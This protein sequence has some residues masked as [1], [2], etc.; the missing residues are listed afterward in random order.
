M[1]LK[2]TKAIVIGSL[3]GVIVMLGSVVLPARLEVWKQE[4]AGQEEETAEAGAASLY[5]SSKLVESET[6]AAENGQQEG[7]AA[8]EKEGV[9]GPALELYVPK[10]QTEP[11]GLVAELDYV[12]ADKISFHG[13]FGYLVYELCVSEDGSVRAERKRAIS[14]EEIGGIHMGGG[15]YTEILANADMAL[16]LPGVR[17]PEIQRQVRYM[18]VEETNE[19][20]GGV[21]T[22]EW[23]SEKTAA[24]DYTD[25]AVKTEWA[26]E[27]SEL[28]RKQ[29]YGEI[30]YGPVEIPEYS[31]EVCGFLYQNGEK[32][33]DVRYGLWMRTENRIV[34]IP[35]FE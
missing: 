34:E 2:D 9:L 15:Y 35:L 17:N 30:L 27:L 5:L 1:R 11:Y 8:E 14:L 18:Y 12:S 28:L 32:L 25:A 23:F 26:G 29:G 33:E 6:E 13:S 4:A 7:V 16:I 20:T 22:P 31:A 21:I 19:I 3:L 24:N 10:V